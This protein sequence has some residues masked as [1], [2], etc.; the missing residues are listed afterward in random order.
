M[1]RKYTTYKKTKKS[2]RNKT[3]KRRQILKF[4]AAKIHPASIIVK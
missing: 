3:R 2:A 1:S 4:D